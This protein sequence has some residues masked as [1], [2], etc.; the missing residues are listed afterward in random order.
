MGYYPNSTLTNGGSARKFILS[1]E[2]PITI[3][4]LSGIDVIMF[5]WNGTGLV[6]HIRVNLTDDD[7]RTLGLQ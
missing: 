7:L 3:A 1:G 4:H 6:G 5:P 2:L